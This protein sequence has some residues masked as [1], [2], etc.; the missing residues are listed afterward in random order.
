M[1]VDAERSNKTFGCR[2]EAKN[3]GV[4]PSSSFDSNLFG[5]DKLHQ[6]EKI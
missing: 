4:D 3:L 5:G 2:D 6:G 1:S